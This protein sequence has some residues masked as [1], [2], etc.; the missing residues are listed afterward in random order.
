MYSFARFT[1][2]TL[3]ASAFLMLS[4][5]GGGGG[6]GQIQTGAVDFTYVIDS[7]SVPV[8]A[9]QAE[10]FGFDFDGDGVVD[11]QFAN[12]L[13]A[14]S[15]GSAGA[16][17]IQ[18]WHTEAVDTGEIILLADIRATAITS[19][20]S[21]DFSIYRGANPDPAPC[22]DVNDT[23]C[24]HHLDGSGGF[25]VD[26]SSSDAAIVDGGIADGNFSGGSGSLTLRL[27][28]SG[29]VIDLTLLEARAEINGITANGFGQS[30]LGGVISGAAL[31]TGFLPAV[32]AAIDATLTA[33]CGPLPR[34]APSC[35]CAPD[36]EGA[37]LMSLTDEDANCDVPQ[38][39]FMDNSLINSLWV[40]DVDTDNDGTDDA[41]SIGVGVTGV[42]ATWTVPGS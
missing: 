15:A 4:A 29:T 30:K 39:E 36:S 20:S 17:D 9:T 5:C 22:A 21:A 7:V 38:Q 3:I 2:M 34:T 10:D 12:V 23:V 8:N 18:G 33:D 6:G 27:A 31:E 14:L 32:W 1:V 41:F 25:D 16:L 13:S 28:F 19:A 24:R 40:P 35:N 26:P 37:S 11:N 42:K